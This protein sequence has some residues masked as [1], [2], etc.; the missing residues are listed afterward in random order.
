[1]ENTVINV[2]LIDDDREYAEITK[3]LLGRFQGRKFNLLCEGD[4]ESGIRKLQADPSVDIVIIDYFLPGDNGI[5]VVKKLKKHN[6]SVPVIFLTTHRNFEMAVEALRHGVH[7]YLLKDAISDNLLAQ[8]ILSVLEHREIYKKLGE[9]EKQQLLA[10]KRAEAIQELIVTINHEIN[11]PLAA[12]KISMDIISRQKLSDQER[13]FLDEFF[14]E[15]GLIEKE[16]TRLRN[17]Q[18]GK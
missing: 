9:A 5:E 3:H 10:R 16:L 1:M 7:D 2:L 14:H 6:I 4:G 18:F 8:T 15:V 11:N 17:V 13:V 12:I